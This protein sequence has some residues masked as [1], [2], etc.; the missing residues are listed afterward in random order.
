MTDMIHNFTVNIDLI[1]DVSACIAV[2]PK[3]IRSARAA[4]GVEMSC[5]Y[6]KKNK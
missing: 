6:K 4:A 3:R 2:V 1:V 5:N